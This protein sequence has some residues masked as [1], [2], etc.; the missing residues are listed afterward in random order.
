MLYPSGVTLRVTFGVASPVVGGGTLGA[1]E[2]YPRF[3]VERVPQELCCD[4][5]SGRLAWA[6]AQSLNLCAAMVAKAAREHRSCCQ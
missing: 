2:P 1:H 3:A 4:K 6:A 5:L